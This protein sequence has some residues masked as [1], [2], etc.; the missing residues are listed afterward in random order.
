MMFLL[1]I[2]TSIQQVEPFNTSCKPY[3]LYSPLK[4]KALRL[5]LLHRVRL[6][7]IIVVLGDP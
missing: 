4:W 6:I 1:C 3:S 5:A 2:L 7:I